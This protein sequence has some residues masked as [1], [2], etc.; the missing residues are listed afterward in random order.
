MGTTALA[1]V[2][3]TEACPT[4]REPRSEPGL[5]PERSLQETRIARN[6]DSALTDAG[7][8]IWS[9]IWNGVLGTG[10]SQRS[11]NGL[12]SAI[13]VWHLTN[14]TGSQNRPGARKHPHGVMP[15]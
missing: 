2:P 15:F 12:Q 1:T 6:G 14:S 8:S 3:G 9:L 7:H 11:H 13:Y 5:D 10:G 4:V